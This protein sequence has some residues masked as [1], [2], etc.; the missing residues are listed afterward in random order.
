MIQRLV[1]F[2]LF[3]A[4]AF[5]HAKDEKLV[6]TSPDTQV[7]VIE[8][9]TSEGCS[10]CPPAD[11]WLS[12]LK[13]S[14]ELWKEIVPVAFHVNY[15]DYI[16]WKDRFASPEFSERQRTEAQAGTGRVYTP[17]FFLDGKEW[18]GLFNG[19][20]RVSRSE[21]M[22]GVLTA[23]QIEGGRFEVEFQPNDESQEK[24]TL[25]AALLGIGLN[26]KVKAGENNGRTLKHDFVAL[27]YKNAPLS[28]GMSVNINLGDNAG[29]H[30]PQRYAAAFWVT[31]SGTLTPL[32]ATG[33]FIELP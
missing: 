24:Y 18:R 21:S 9:Y 2:S 23:T 33:G 12:Q 1:L 28:K 3:L 7:R 16:G 8:L 20:S 26:S 22:P 25:H 10:S 30:D 32:Q 5:A 19:R 6:F 11:R 17:G 27:E 14:P 29:K 15:W 13:D 4:T 31:P